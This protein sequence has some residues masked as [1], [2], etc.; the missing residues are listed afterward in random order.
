MGIDSN[1][2]PFVGTGVAAYTSLEQM[3]AYRSVTGNVFY[4]VAVS[5]VGNSRVR[6]TRAS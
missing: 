1:T 4:K 2:L 6:A 5:P 3:K